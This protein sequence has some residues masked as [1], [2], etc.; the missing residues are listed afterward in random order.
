MVAAI[1]E[2]FCASTKSRAQTAFLSSSVWVFFF[3][4]VLRGSYIWESFHPAFKLIFD[5]KGGGGGGG[6]GGRNKK[7]CPNEI[8]HLG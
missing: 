7:V 2:A 8:D 1:N 5:E 4:V 3:S 6:G